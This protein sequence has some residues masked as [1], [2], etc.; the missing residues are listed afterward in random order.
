[1]RLYNEQEETTKIITIEDYSTFKTL[2]QSKYLFGLLIA[3]TIFV[4]VQALFA[5]LD[6]GVVLGTVDLICHT[7]I[8]VSLWIFHMANQKSD[9]IETKGVKMFQI[10]HAVK[11]SVVFIF[12]LIALIMIFLAWVNK[13]NLA[14]QALVKAKASTEEGV[15]K[16]AK[17]VCTKVFWTYF[18][19]TVVYIVFMAA[20]CNYYRY[21]MSTV[22]Q[23]EKYNAKGKHFWKEM[24]AASIYFFVCAGLLVLFSILSVLGVI[25]KILALINEN[26]NF[27][28][29]AGGIGILSSIP[30]ILL[31][32]LL[33]ALGL[34]LNK[35]STTLTNTKTSY[36]KEIEIE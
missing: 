18:I 24:K 32:A 10:A 6:G 13:A 5:F 28:S 19:L 4:V 22:D 26:T 33:V 25:P 12:F 27:A 14:N 31:A 35:A 7:L 17:L 11:F 30:R 16:A 36:Q 34:L 21:V 23:F 9:K 8:A 3:Y 15:L 20:V 29:F 1:M 2:L